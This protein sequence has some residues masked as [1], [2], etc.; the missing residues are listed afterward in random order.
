METRISPILLLVMTMAMLAAAAQPPTRR[1]MADL[2]KGPTESRVPVPVP[3]PVSASVSV[4]VPAHRRADQQEPGSSCSSE[5]EWN[6]M[7]DSWQRCAAGRWSIVVSTAK[8]TECTPQGMAD[9][10]STEDKDGSDDDDDDDG[11]D[12]NDGNGTSGGGRVQL[13]STAT[14]MVV[15][16]AAFVMVQ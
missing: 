5:G 11:S 12:G 3:V 2:D 9:D 1:T 14:Q 7:G 10:I 6:C 4:S 13:A 16:A 15:F 8:G